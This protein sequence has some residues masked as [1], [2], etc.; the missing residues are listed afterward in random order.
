MLFKKLIAI[1]EDRAMRQEAREVDRAERE[2]ARSGQELLTFERSWDLQQREYNLRLA[3][4]K[5]E[6]REEDLKER[7]RKLQR[8]EKLHADQARRCRELE[9]HFDA[10]S[11]LKLQDIMHKKDDTSDALVIYQSDSDEDLE[12]VET[13]KMPDFEHVDFNE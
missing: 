9:I 3:V 7:E 12:M 5:L 8:Q 2:L 1:N 13:P 11:A 6:V 10:L 4:K